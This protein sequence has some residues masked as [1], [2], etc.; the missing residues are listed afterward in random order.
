MSEQKRGCGYRKIGGLYLVCDPGLELHCDGLPLEL[1]ACDCCGFVPPF[2]RNLQRIHAQYISQAEEN[3]HVQK[4]PFRAGKNGKDEGGEGCYCPE[5]CPICGT[6]ALDPDED[7]MPVFGLMFVGKQGYTPST[8]IKE[9]FQM[10]VSKRIPDIPSWLK[11]NETWILLAHNEVPKVSLEEIKSNGLHTVEP[12]L[13]QAVFYAFKPSRVEMPVWKG[14]LTDQ[15]I[16]K[17][18]EQGITPVFLEP[19]PQNKKRHDPDAQMLI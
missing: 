3:L 7:T 16:L 19:T 5:S 6:I 15:Q 13:I 11:F 10:G 8:F 18:E 14:S 4:Y 2:S 12:E 9:A 17:L 1:K